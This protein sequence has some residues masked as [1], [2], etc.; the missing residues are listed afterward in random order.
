MN[1]GKD[2]VVHHHDSSSRRTLDKNSHVNWRVYIKTRF[3]NVEGSIWSLTII[4]DNFEAWTPQLQFS[5]PVIYE[6]ETE[7]SISVTVCSLLRKHLLKQIH[8]TCKQTPHAIMSRSISSV[9]VR[10]HCM[11]EAKECDLCGL[12]PSVEAGTVIRWGPSI[13][14]W[15]SWDR[16]AIAWMVFPKPWEIQSR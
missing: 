15:Y 8:A 12:L 6:R 3:Q 1:L 16:N 13:P 2:T 4:D 14:F 10:L 9:S 5:D 11:N 7:I